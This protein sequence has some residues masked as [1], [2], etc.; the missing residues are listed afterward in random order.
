MNVRI[1]LIVGCMFFLPLAA[2]ADDYKR[3]DFRESYERIYEKNGIKAP[4]VENQD[5]SGEDV[6]HQSPGHDEYS[7]YEWSKKSSGAL[8]RDS[9]SELRPKSADGS[10]SSLEPYTE[11]KLEQYKRE[12]KQEE[13]P[14]D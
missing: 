8:S 13:S 6:D 3:K 9:G 4:R 12:I 5:L 1:F 10:Y 11:Q 7:L 14:K 2:H